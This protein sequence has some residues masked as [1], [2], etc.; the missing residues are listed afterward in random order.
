MVYVQ[1]KF[2]K[3][4]MPTHDC[5]KVRLLLKSKQ[6]KVVQNNPF[7]IR[8][9]HSTHEYRQDIT[10]GVDAGYENIGLSAVTEDKEI[11]SS[12][13]ELLKEMSERIRE[14]AMYRRIRR[15]RLRYRKPGF[16][17]NKPEGWLAP[18]IQHKLD[19][20]IRIIEKLCSIMPITEIVVEVASFD[21]QKIKDPSITGYEYQQGDQTGFWNVREYVL[22][23][24][25][26][27]CQ[28]L[29][30][31]NKQLKPILEVHHIIPRPA[32]SDLPSNLVTLCNQCHTSANHKGFLKNWKPNV[33]GFKA[34]TFMTSVR[35]KIVNKLREIYPEKTIKNTYGYITKGSRIILKQPKTHFNDAFCIAGGTDQQ[36]LHP[37]QIKQVRRNNRSL[38]KWY[39]AK[40]ID[41][42]SGKPEHAAVLNCGRTTRNKNHNGEN[43]KKYRGVKVS[44][45]RISIRRQRYFYQPNDLV[46]YNGKIHAV[47][48]T[49]NL[50]K[51][52]ALKDITKVP[53]VNEL[54]PYRFSSGFVYEL[55]A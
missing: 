14:R 15:S 11:F 49:Q 42:R 34:E 18:S 55:C 19:S 40:Y 1:N 9:Q 46:K 8:L 31:K 5:R 24:D 17:D 22:Y 48:G 30:C 12:N 16:N 2:G 23:R 4:L 44:K 47:R 13:V 53:S 26:H 54:K 52:I 6:A 50:G 25:R 41:I 43:L 20:H 37:Y 39:D 38:Q 36:R 45:G 32:G 35:W 21:I 51:Y 28:H 29:N 27:K 10:L 33:N 3:P 7:T